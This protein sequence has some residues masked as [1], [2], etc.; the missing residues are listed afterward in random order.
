MA[1]QLSLDEAIEQVAELIGKTDRAVALTGSGISVDSGIPE[2]RGARGV[3]A[4]YDPAEYATVDAFVADPEKVWGM[5]L[6][7]GRQIA[8]AEPN[9]GHFALAELERMGHISAVVTQ[10]VDGLHQ[11]AGSTRVIEFHGNVNRLSCIECFRTYP[12]SEISFEQVPPLCLCG[13]VLKPD[14]VLYGET[15][16]PQAGAEAQAAVHDCRVMLTIGTSAETQPASILP[17]TA[18]SVG[19][20]VVEINV[21][22]TVITTSA[23]DFFLQGSSSDILPALVQRIKS[24]DLR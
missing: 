16:P 1:H 9:P 5:M 13:G 22:P 14:V 18:K 6:E 15:I 4:K 20:T 23:T 10:N 21:E 2:F 7:L 12:S 24:Q 11:R 19:A 17:S 3:W 8:Q